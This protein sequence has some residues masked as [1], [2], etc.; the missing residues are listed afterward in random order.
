LYVLKTNARGK[1]P[2]EWQ[3]LRKMLGYGAKGFDEVY[4]KLA[5]NFSKNC[6]VLLKIYQCFLSKPHTPLLLW[7]FCA[8][9]KHFYALKKILFSI[10]FGK[11][12][13]KDWSYN[14]H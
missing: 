2:F 10:T 3:G 11:S 4:E 5:N 6:F 1:R 13:F 14:Y 12:M 7:F 9:L 8:L